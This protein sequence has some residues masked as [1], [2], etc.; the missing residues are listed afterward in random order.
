MRILKGRSDGTQGMTAWSPGNPRGNKTLFPKL[1][2][3]EWGMWGG[4]GMY[5]P[6]L[7]KIHQS[8]SYTR[9]NIYMYRDTFNNKQLT[10]YKQ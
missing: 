7:L 8:F 4:G 5:E 9:M 3:L 10:A 2:F 1:P 6:L